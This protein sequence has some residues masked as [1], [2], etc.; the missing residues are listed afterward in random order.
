MFNKL[1]LYVYKIKVF[2][3]NA[4]YLSI[5]L[6]IFLTAFCLASEYDGQ[7]SFACV[8]GYSIFRAPIF[9]FL[10]QGSVT[11]ISSGHIPQDLKVPGF[12]KIKTV[13][14]DF[15]VY[16]QYEPTKFLQSYPIEG[17]DVFITTVYDI[18]KTNSNTS[19]LDNLINYKVIAYKGKDADQ[20]V[21][22]LSDKA[23]CRLWKKSFLCN[24]QMF[25][26]LHSWP[27]TGK[28]TGW[29]FNHDKPLDS[30][31]DYR[32]IAFEITFLAS[33]VGGALWLANKYVPLPS[34]S[35]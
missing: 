23:A 10:N 2:M 28:S 7:P 22:K 3:K 20:A 31:P 8:R 5:Y 17:V 27:R 4:I 16:D 29:A 34:L 9:A 18:Q 35:K 15:N 25:I 19:Q 30:H 12:G 6:S 21:L 26:P 14:Y 33:A 1:I 32:Q 11:L 24:S 13:T